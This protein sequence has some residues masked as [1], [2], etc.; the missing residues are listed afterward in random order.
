VAKLLV[1]TSDAVIKVEPN[2]ILR[3]SIHSPQQV[4]KVIINIGKVLIRWIGFKG[5]FQKK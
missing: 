3:G 4:I 2:L 5:L 1:S